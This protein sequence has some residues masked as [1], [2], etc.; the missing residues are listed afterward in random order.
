MNFP[1]PPMPIVTNCSDMDNLY[2]G[3]YGVELGCLKLGRVF[4]LRWAPFRCYRDHRHLHAHHGSYVP[5]SSVRFFDWPCY[6]TK[7]VPASYTR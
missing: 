6:Y 4:N 7:R 5:P 3:C 1:V 2:Y